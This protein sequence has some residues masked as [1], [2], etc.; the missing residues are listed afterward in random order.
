MTL[1]LW[2]LIIYRSVCWY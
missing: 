2:K 1:F